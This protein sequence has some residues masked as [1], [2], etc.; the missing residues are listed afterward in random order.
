L[1]ASAP[2]PSGVA[3]IDLVAASDFLFISTAPG[4]TALCL[5]PLVPA[6][7]IGVVI[8]DGGYDFSL[9]QTVNHHA[10]Q[11]GVDGFS[12]Q[13]CLSICTLSGNCATV[14]GHNQI[15]ATGLVGAEC[16]SDADCQSSPESEDGVC[17][18]GRLCT[19]GNIG[20]PCDSNAACDSTPDADDGFCRPLDSCSSGN[21]GVACRSDAECDTALDAGNGSCGATAPHLGVCNEALQV[22]PLGRNS[23][24]GS[25]SIG[26]AMQPSS[27][28]LPVEI[29][30]ESALP[31]G[32]EG[33]GVES[34]FAFTT[35]LIRSTILN[36]NDQHN[37]CSAPVLGPPCTTDDDC[38]SSPGSN[39]GVCGQRLTVDHAGEAFD[40]TDWANSNGPGCLVL[41][42]PA[43][44]GSGFGDVISRF[45]L[46]AP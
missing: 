38:D 30:V 9:V 31:C 40:C 10:G 12:A 41:S 29:T 37:A 46:C 3:T 45:S 17:G 6:A 34:R 44:H 1:H 4:D 42:I 36:L 21:V 16:R 24:P 5:R 15:C 43:L 27:A 8:C 13:Q 19:R 7:G 23:L 39:N 28:G 20:A 26:S 33:P 14:E 32:D 25:V 35:D 11:V 2:D 18:L 22:E